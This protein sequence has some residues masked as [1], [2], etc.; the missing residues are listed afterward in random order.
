MATTIRE[1]ARICGVSRGTVDRALN[2]RGD[3]SEETRDRIV[4]TAE[5]LGYRPHFLAQ[6]LARG[7]TQSLGFVVF[8][9][10]NVFI[11]QFLEAAET[12]AREIGYFSYITVTDKVQKVEMECLEHLAARQVDGIILLGVNIGSRFEKYLS[13]LPMPVMSV[14]NRISPKFSHVGV[15]DKQAVKECVQHI[16]FKGYRSLIYVSP[17]LRYRGVSNI[18]AQQ[19]RYEGFTEA[20][21]ETDPVCRTHV[22]IEKNYQNILDWIAAEQERTAILCSSDVYALQILDFLSH[23]GLRVPEDVGLMGFDNIETLKHVRPRLTTVDHQ[24]EEMGR[25]AVQLM[26]TQIE[27]ESHPS[28]VIIAHRILAGETL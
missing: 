13:S 8:N 24:V 10:K 15:D 28:E 23:R 12:H 5:K 11:A 26:A 18:A 19:K 2:G 1:I 27:E 6:S 16:V 20:A 14:G 9:L 7:R 25:I 21:S 3:I 22:L 4:E 17:P